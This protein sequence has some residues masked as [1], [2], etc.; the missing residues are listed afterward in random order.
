MAAE[1]KEETFEF[2]IQGFGLHWEADAVAR[3]IRDGEKENPRMPH[4]ETLLTMKVRL[5]SVLAS[6]QCFRRA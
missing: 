3:S 4:A 5:L 1:Y 6:R 2:P